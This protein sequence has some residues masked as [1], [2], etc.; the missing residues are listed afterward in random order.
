MCWP[1][2]AWKIISR[3]G[4]YAK[5]LYGNH[6]YVTNYRAFLP[7]PLVKQKGIVFVEI[8]QTTNSAM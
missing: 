4:K 6:A 1:W 3:R 5:V 8:L 2:K 7:Y